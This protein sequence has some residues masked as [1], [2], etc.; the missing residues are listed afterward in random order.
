MVVVGDSTWEAIN[1]QDLDEE[2][3]LIVAAQADPLVFE[4]LYRRYR[5]P[6]HRYLLAHLSSVDDAADLTQHVFLKALE[7]LP[8]YRDRG[9][10]FSAW[11]FRIARNAAIDRIR[12]RRPSVDWDR[13][14]EAEQPVEQTTPES[15]ALRNDAMRRFDALVSSLDD[16]KR[17]L[18]SL[19]FV[20]GLTTPEI[21]RVLG[22]S[23]AAVRV[24]LSRTLRILKEHH[25]D[26]S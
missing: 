18:L 20:A 10:P 7:N 5:E 2:R 15:E 25:R 24:Q 1:K 14:Q 3:A 9:V 17:D 22:K 26:Q 21:A 12:S 6:I 23:D 11:L 16:D 8:V 19:R 4:T 13:I